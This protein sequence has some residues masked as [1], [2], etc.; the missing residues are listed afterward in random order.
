MSN[1]IIV[2]ISFLIGW[3]ILSIPV[4][5][6]S[7]A[8]SRRSSFGNAMIVSLVSI[9]IYVVLTTFLHFIG[10]IIGIIII[11]LIIREIYNVGWGGA[12]VIGVLSL[13]IF[14][15]IALILGALHLA[16]LLI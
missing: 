2:L 15:I 3:I 10:A 13:V 1:L 5:L 8:V 4:W 14:V 16:S 12:I 6:A 11:L 9:V 7:K